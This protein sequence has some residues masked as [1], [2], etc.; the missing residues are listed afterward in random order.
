M[1]AQPGH[2]LEFPKFVEFYEEERIT[3][4]VVQGLLSAHYKISP[5]TDFLLLVQIN[6]DNLEQKLGS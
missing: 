4:L 6:R 2:L 1:W 3:E 5:K